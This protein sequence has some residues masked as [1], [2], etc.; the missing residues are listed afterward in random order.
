MQ[1]YKK[2]TT[3]AYWIPLLFLLAACTA[4]PRAMLYQVNYMGRI[5]QKS[6]D[7]T[8][9]ENSIAKEQAV[10][11]TTLLSGDL[12][13]YHLVQIRGKE[14]LH[15][16]DFH[17]LAVFMQSGTGKIYMGKDSVKVSAGSMIFIPHGMTHQFVNIGP[18]PAVAIVVFSPPFNGKDVVEIE[19]DDD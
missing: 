8:V 11:S 2:H 9:W 4:S 17:D 5:D 16:H 7:R 18:S 3:I 14:S 19:P 1:I 12:A 6:L 10:A 13:S 15:K